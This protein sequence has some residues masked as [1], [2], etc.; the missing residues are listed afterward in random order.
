M[1]KKTK[2]A[3]SLLTVMTLLLT[4]CGGSAGE[5][6]AAETPKVDKEQ[7][8]KIAKEEKAALKTDFKVDLDKI[9]T[10]TVQAGTAVHDPSIL[11]ADGT[12]YIYGSHMAA[13]KSKNLREWE[14]F[15]GGMSEV[16]PIY[17]ELYKIDKG[18]WSFTGS[19]DSVVY[20]DGLSL[21]APDVK[22]SEKRGLYYM[23]FCTTSD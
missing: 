22:Y 15:V 14:G 16:N 2:M 1:K 18:P 21:W 3:V 6:K 7:Q 23:Y 8:A 5:K 9:K 20:N 12:Y 13:A 11:E 10:G 19:P 17:G 4:G